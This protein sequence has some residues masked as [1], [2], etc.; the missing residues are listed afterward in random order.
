LNL[1]KKI[2]INPLY[3]YLFGGNVILFVISFFLDKLY[4][5]CWYLFLAIHLFVLLDFILLFINKNGIEGQRKLPEK[6]SNG[7]ENTVEI[8]LKNNYGFQVNAD[9]ID[10]IPFQFQKRDF[11]IKKKIKPNGK[12]R[13]NYQLRPLE[14]GEYHFG[15]LNVLVSCNSF[16]KSI[17]LMDKLWCQTIRHLF[18]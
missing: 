6:L 4:P 10:E 13:I 8:S 18:N 9:V 16:Q 7:D 12:T 5:F 2:F 3:F 17:V 14:R 15:F 11:L 1:Y